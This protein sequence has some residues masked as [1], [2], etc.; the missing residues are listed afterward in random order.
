MA[1]RI[2]ANSNLYYLV[3]SKS[4]KLLFGT[5]SAANPPDIDTA[6]PSTNY[7]MVMDSSGN[8]GINQFNPTEKLHVAGNV[9]VGGNITATGNIAAK[10]QDVA[11]WVTS[12]KP[13]PAGTVVILDGTHSNQVLPSVKP[14]DTRVAGVVSEMPGVILGEA[15]D[16]KVKVATTGRV[17]VK[18]DATKR[19]VQIGDLLV[20]SDRE[21]I[22][23]K[24]EP[25]DI[26][27]RSFHQPGTI[28]GKALE[29]LK[30]GEGEILVLLSLQ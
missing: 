20:T 21:G 12:P 14:Y 30:E 4:D 2:K 13:M 9:L 19:P 5:V 1:L 18:V 27:G 23:M 25:I 3:G 16:D 15:G 24:S 8:V 6:I 26:S 11:E 28:L 17:K 22:A 29:P 7:R 10:F